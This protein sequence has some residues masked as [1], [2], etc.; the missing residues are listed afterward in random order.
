MSSIERK[1]VLQT[2]C[3]VW[4]KQT[5]FPVGKT[6]CRKSLRQQ[7][8]WS[9]CTNVQTGLGF[10]WLDMS[11]NRCFCFVTWLTIQKI[12]KMF[13]YYRI[14]RN[15]ETSFLHRENKYFQPFLQ[16]TFP[17]IFS[18]WRMFKSVFYFSDVKSMTYNN[19]TRY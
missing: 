9:D 11:Q 16:Q 7:S 10:P 3:S 8:L 1:P 4:Q 6:L 19:F 12:S 17:T 5:I 13:A 15:K 14:C 2:V 18:T